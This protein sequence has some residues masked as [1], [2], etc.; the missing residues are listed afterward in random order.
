MA[1]TI[2]FEGFAGVRLRATVEGRA[3]DPPVLLLHGGGQSRQVW[4]DVVA[5]LVTARRYVVNL[6]LRG[7]G[8]SE[9]PEDGR[10][11]A[12]AF[13]DDIRA[14]VAQMEARPVIVAATITGW[15]AVRALGAQAPRL[16]AGL[17]LI[18]FPVDP[19]P[20]S[21]ERVRERLSR[22]RENARSFDHRWLHLQHESPSRILVEEV[23]P[24]LKLPILFVRGS[25]SDLASID[26]AAAFTGLLPDV[27][28][29]EVPDAR[30]VMAEDRMV[31]TGKLIVDF[32]ERRQPGAALDYRCG[33]DA[34]TL[35]DALGCFATGV[36][37]VTTRAP[38]GTPRGTTV[39]S[40]TSVSLDPP[41]LLVCL[42]RGTDSATAL[43]AAD[44]FAVNVLQAGQQAA[45]H[46]FATRGVDRFAEI[47]WIPGEFGAP[48][49]P[50]SLG[51]FECRRH[52]VYE[53]GDHV[54]LIGHVENARFQPFRDPLLFFRGAYR[55][56]NHRS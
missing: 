51:A 22:D 56:L 55:K 31:Q 14:V 50:D 11:D 9:W 48:V 37:I 46:R 20:E 38:D 15:A 27:E 32:L 17:V 12:Q 3:G 47:D 8:D 35:R 2:E 33:S 19:T 29:I 36:T 28:A 52:A 25:H 45:S 42:S 40:F 4:R 43:C 49:M 13:V 16:A 5:Q 53:A 23:A 41:L 26:A 10:Y 30:V 34:R 1:E 21:L 7:H 6:D 24:A 54:I 39:N 18:D 44:H